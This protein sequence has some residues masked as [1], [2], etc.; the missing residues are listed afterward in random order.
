MTSIIG[1]SVF[2]ESNADV[3]SRI[4]RERFLFRVKCNFGTCGL[5]QNQM[6]PSFLKSISSD[7]CDY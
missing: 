1:V 4:S 6:D 3:I 2:V 5:A 7:T